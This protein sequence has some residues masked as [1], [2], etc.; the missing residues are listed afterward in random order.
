[1]HLSELNGGQYNNHSNSGHPFLGNNNYLN[2]GNDN[3]LNG[4]SFVYRN[5]GKGQAHK[6]NNNNE[7]FYNNLNNMNSNLSL[8]ALIKSKEAGENSANNKSS[9]IDMGHKGSS[10]NFE[11][12]LD[13]KRLL[14][15]EE[16]LAAKPKNS[17]SH[18]I[19]SLLMTNNSVNQKI[20][21]KYN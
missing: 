11:K 21:T 6:I 15:I 16:K 18:K 13:M 17:Y 8:S 20:E 10:E 7:F 5:Q 2:L 4:N 12:V 9:S 1:M 3:F 19:S 14:S